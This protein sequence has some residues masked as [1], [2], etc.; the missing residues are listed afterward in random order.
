M[1]VDSHA[2]CFESVDRPAG[3]ASGTEH[4][5]WVQAAHAWHHQPA[6]RVRDRA[7]ASSRLLDPKGR[8]DLANLPDC[9]FRLDHQRGRVVWTLDGE[10]CTKHFFPPNLRDLEF[11]PH[12][13]IGEMDYAGVDVALI[14]TNPMLGRDS[15]YLAECVRA[16]Y[17]YLE[18]SD[19]VI[20]FPP[21]AKADLIRR[22]RE[23]FGLIVLGEVGRKRESTG[24]GALIRDIE[25]ALGAGSWKVFVEAAEFFDEKFKAD[26]V[27]EIAAAVPVDK[28]LF[29]L[30]GRWLKNIHHHQV[31][32]MIR[33]LVGELGSE[34]NLA[35]IVPEDILIVE[36][37]RANVGVGMKL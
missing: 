37:Q 29:E 9:H 2:Y 33:F 21:G 4:L 8:Y 25:E 13:L 17:R 16:G 6:F 20:H 26:L 1:I 12:S 10:D 5:R 18:V 31:H 28:L 7:P 11:T 15:A 32:E 34:V 24:A 3:F 22:A 19:N 27:R 23:E 35:N 36:T 30:P 14:H